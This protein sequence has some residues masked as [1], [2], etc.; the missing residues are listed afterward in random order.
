MPLHLSGIRREHV[1]ARLGAV[2]DQGRA[3]TLPRDVRLSL[4]RAATDAIHVG[5]RAR[6]LELD[7]FGRLELLE[8]A[9]EDGHETITAQ[10][11][12]ARSN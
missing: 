11:P 5:L 2:R 10:L 7:Y 12:P 1:E 8:L 3:T 4:L 6:G 9:L